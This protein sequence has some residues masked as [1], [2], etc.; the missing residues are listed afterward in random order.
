MAVN[1]KHMSKGDIIGIIAPFALAI[2][3]IFT[4]TMGLFYY[5]LVISLLRAFVV[6]L[7]Y[8]I[9]KGTEDP[10]KKFIKERRLCR[11]MGLIIM[12]LDV[13]YSSVLLLFIYKKPSKFFIKHPWSILVYVV[14]ALYKFLMGRHHFRK[15]RE[16]FSP[17]REVICAMSY[18]DG[19]VSLLNAGVL[20][21]FVTNYLSSGFEIAILSVGVLFITFITFTLAL[22][23]IKSRRVPAELKQY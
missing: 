18:F 15:S 4:G 21:F 16:S 9:V 13:S 17:Y 12:I 22:K 11:L 2:F 1:A 7:Q 19:M 10:K 6:G 5:Y 23:M 14:Y 8:L 3:T 20:V